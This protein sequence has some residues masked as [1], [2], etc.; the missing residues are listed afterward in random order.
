M[1]AVLPWR[2]A[3][4]APVPTDRAIWL[5]AIWLRANVITTTEAFVDAEGFEGWVEWRN[6]EWIGWNGLSVC[7]SLG[8]EVVPLDWCE[9]AERAAKAPT[10]EMDLS[11]NVYFW[12]GDLRRALGKVG[13][14]SLCRL[15]HGPTGVVLS[16]RTDGPF[17]TQQEAADRLMAMLAVIRHCGAEA[18]PQMAA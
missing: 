15:V 18:L 16:D 3:K 10:W 12:G 17:A 8:S 5:R 4:T 14:F 2:D 6:G 11:A 9:L 7:G 1:N 13:Y